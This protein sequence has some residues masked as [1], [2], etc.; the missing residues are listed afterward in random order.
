MTANG[1]RRQRHAAIATLVRWIPVATTQKAAAQSAKNIIATH[2]RGIH[3]DPLP[4]HRS[5][6]LLRRS[7]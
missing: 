2:T 3:L 7:F 5:V 1:R 4:Y 6:T